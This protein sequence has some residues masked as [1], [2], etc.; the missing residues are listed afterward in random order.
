[1]SALQML[2]I[3]LFGRPKRRKQPERY[4]TFWL[5][6]IGKELDNKIKKI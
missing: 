2:R 4:A 6:I 5:K 3:C 1:L